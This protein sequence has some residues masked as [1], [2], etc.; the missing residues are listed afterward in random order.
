MTKGELIK[1]LENFPND[2]VVL[3]RWG[4][5]EMNNDMDIRGV[6]EVKVCKGIVYGEYRDECCYCD[7]EDLYYPVKKVIN[8]I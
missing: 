8:I 4:R 3:A 1:L 6:E 2:T 5:N 7:N